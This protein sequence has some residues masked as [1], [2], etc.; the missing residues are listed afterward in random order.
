LLPLSLAALS[1]VPPRS[2]PM[3]FDIT[4]SLRSA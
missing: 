3:R 1:A 4:S 2:R